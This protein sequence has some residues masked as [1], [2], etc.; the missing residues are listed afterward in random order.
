M[1]KLKVSGLESKVYRP[2]SKLLGLELLCQATLF[3][4]P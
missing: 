2:E 4:V 1:M 3:K